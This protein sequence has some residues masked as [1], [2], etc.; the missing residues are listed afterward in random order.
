MVVYENVFNN[1]YYA[2]SGTEQRWIQKEDNNWFMYSIASESY[3]KSSVNSVIVND[4][5]REFVYESMFYLENA[6]RCGRLPRKAPG[7]ARMVM[8][9]P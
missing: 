4:N 2:T 1:K 3:I 8:S 6:C 9:R 7:C 5:I